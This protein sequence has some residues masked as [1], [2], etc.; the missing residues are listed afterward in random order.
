MRRHTECRSVCTY[1]V[2]SP[3]ERRIAYRGVADTLGQNWDLSPGLRN[4][5]VFVID[6]GGGAPV[7]V[8]NNPAF[9][10]WPDWSPDGRWVVFASNRGRVASTGQIYAV[11]PDGRD[12]RQ[13]TGGDWSRVQPAFSASGDRI[14]VYESMENSA[15][16]LGHIASFAV[17][18]GD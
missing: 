13:L 6:A 9:D 17:S 7:N 18:L 1:P 2:P 3:D 8:S 5:E 12:L 11:R 14:F 16:E 10:G 4:S 15:F